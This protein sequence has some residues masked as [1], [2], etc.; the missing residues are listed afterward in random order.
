MKGAVRLRK[1]EDKQLSQEAWGIESADHEEFGKDQARKLWKEYEEKA[2]L[3]TA[4]FNGINEL[5]DEFARSWKPKHS[6][7]QIQAIKDSKQLQYLVCQIYAWRILGSNWSHSVKENEL[8]EQKYNSYAG[9]KVLFERLSRTRSLKK[10][11]L[12]YV[13]QAVLAL[14]LELYL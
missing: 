10:A 14:P 2:Y 1:P 11:K 5:M 9:K 6:D 12:D 7:E 3:A 4:A 8:D 13:V